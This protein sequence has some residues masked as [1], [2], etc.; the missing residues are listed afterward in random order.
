MHSGTCE[1]DAN[2][3]NTSLAGDVM[4]WRSSCNQT[5]EIKLFVF[6]VYF[7]TEVT[8]GFSIC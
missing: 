5:L 7:I 4:M 3:I 1:G 2:T 8:L 6:I